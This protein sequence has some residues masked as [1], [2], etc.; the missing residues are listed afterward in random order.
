M[1]PYSLTGA[2]NELILEN[3]Q[4]AAN[5]CENLGIKLIVRLPLIP[6]MNDDEENIIK[7]AEFVSSLKGNVLLNILPYH[8]YGATKYEY[9]GK[10]YETE[11]LPLQTKEFWT[12]VKKLLERTEVCY[13]IGG[14]DI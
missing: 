4:K 11:D 6:T 12:Y 1:I 5:L 7:T 8:N 2:P 10:T 9:L 13:S 3:I 14:Y